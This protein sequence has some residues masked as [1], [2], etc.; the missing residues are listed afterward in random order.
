MAFNTYCFICSWFCGCAAWGRALRRLPISAPHGV[1]W[2]YQ[3]LEDPRYLTA[4]SGRCAGYRMQ[5]FGLPITN[6][7]PLQQDSLAFLPYTVAQ[8][9]SLLRFVTLTA[10]LLPHSVPLGPPRLQGEGK[11]MPPSWWQT[12]MGRTTG[13]HLCKQSVISPTTVTYVQWNHCNIKEIKRKKLKMVK[14]KCLFLPIYPI[15]Y[16]WLF[17]QWR[18]EPNGRCSADYTFTESNLDDTI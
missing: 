9:L 16:P 7:C 15:S 2:A 6:A 8:K 18:I 13:D 3:G 12:G 11:E 10:F 5:S 4:M 1:S 17:I 14:I